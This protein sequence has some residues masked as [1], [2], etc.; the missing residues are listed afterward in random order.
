MDRKFLILNNTFASQTRRSHKKAVSFLTDSTDKMLNVPALVAIYNLFLPYFT[1]Y[2]D[3][4]D[5]VGLLEGTYKGKT[6]MFETLIDGLTDKLK[7]WEGKIRNVF[8]EDSPMEIEIFPNKRNPFYKGTYEQRRGALRTLRNKIASLLPDYPA[9][10][11]VHDEIEAYTALCEAA[12]STQ[13]GKEA[14]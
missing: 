2:I 10:A 12:R 13:Q 8:P 11:T 14:T 1:A 4:N 5:A 9:L 7:V 6:N 3:L